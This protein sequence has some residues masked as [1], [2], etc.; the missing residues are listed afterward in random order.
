MKNIYVA[1]WGQQIQRRSRVT[2]IVRILVFG[3]ATLAVVKVRGA[4]EG[5]APPALTL[6][7]F[8]PPARI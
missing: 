7:E 4:R 8:G 1:P 2:G 3:T 6:A 5:S